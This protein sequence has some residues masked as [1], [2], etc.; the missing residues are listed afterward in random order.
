M[1]KRTVPSVQLP[2]EPIAGHVYIF[3]VVRERPITPPPG[4]WDSTW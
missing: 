2:A 1:S 3:P 4:C